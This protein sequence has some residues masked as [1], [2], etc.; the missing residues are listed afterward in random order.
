MART[1][2]LR[3]TLAALLPL[4]LVRPGLAAAEDAAATAPVPAGPACQADAPPRGTAEFAALLE[5][6]RRS[7]SA[8]ESE[9]VPL[10]GRGYG[11]AA[12]PDPVRDLV[13]LHPARR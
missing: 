8:R 1:R 7:E 13:D 5:R 12:P 2:S 6:L 10:D 3:R 9:V 4:L 11:Y